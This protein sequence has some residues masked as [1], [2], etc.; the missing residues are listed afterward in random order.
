MVIELLDQ[1]I[2]EGQPAQQQAARELKMAHERGD[3]VEESARALHDAMRN[4]PYLTRNPGDT[5]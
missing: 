4:D 1:V 2:R 5:A 3:D